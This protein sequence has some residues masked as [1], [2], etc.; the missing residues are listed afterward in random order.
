[1]SD[2]FALDDEGN[3]AVAQEAAANPLDPHDYRKG[4]FTGT[5][6]AVGQGLLRG[7]VAVGR[8]LELAGSVP[9]AFAEP[10]LGK[11]EGDLT[12]A[13][14]GAIDPHLR[15]AT[16]Y[17]TPNAEE[18]GAAAN[19]LGGFAEAGIPLALGGGNPVPLIATA[20]LS[21]AMR[22]SDEGVGPNTAAAVGT[23][24]AAANAVGFKVPFLGN[25]LLTRVAS[26]AAGNMAVGAGSTEAS[27]LL[28]QA[29]GNNE[30]A[31]QYNPLD[32]K[33]R[34]VDTLMG[35]AF[36]TLAHFADGHVTPTERDAAL[37]TLNAKHAAEDT[38]PGTPADLGAAQAHQAAID[39]AV[40]SILR[41]EP[42]VAPPA[43][44]EANFKPRDFGPAPEVPAELKA[45]DAELT[46]PTLNIEPGRDLTPDQRAIEER[47]RQQI[48][49]DPE[50]AVEA[51]SKLPDSAGGKII[52][53]DTARELSPDYL[54]DRTQ[55][56]A[57]HEPASALMKYLFAKKLA[58]E[59]GPGERPVVLFSAGGTG[60]GKTTALEKLI[61]ARVAE[62]QV[63]YDTNLNTFDSGVKKIDQALA[64]RKEVTIAYVYRHPIEALVKGALTRAMRQEKEFG[65]GRTVPVPDHIDTHTGSRDVIEQLMAHYANDKRVQFQVIDN[66]HG[67]NGAR[68]ANIA[69]IPK[70]APEAHNALR[71]QAY[72][73]LTEE[74]QA[75]RISESVYRGFSAGRE[76]PANDTRGMVE[77]SG[78]A[79]GGIPQQADGQAQV[80]DGWASTPGDNPGVTHF[81]LEGT[82]ATVDALPIGR[83]GQVLYFAKVN[84]HDIGGSEFYS[85][86]D[87]KAAALEAASRTIDLTPADRKWFGDSQALDAN[88]QPL[89]LFRGSPK[90]GG[91]TLS[92]DGHGLIYLTEDR[93]YAAQ[94]AGQGADARVH[95]FILKTEKPLQ[96]S[97]V[98]D[99]PR[100]WG[101]DLES[102]GVKDASKLIAAD[103][104][105]KD[106]QQHRV[107][108]DAIIQGN[109]PLL[110]AIKA[111]GYDSV[112]YRERMLEDSNPH[113][114]WVAWDKTRL[115]AAEPPP[116][117]K[118]FTATGRQIDVRPKVVEASK[119]LTSDHPKYPQ[120]LQPRQ[121]GARAASSAQVSEI[122]QNLRP[123]L[124]GQS[125]TADTGAPI[126]GA[127]NA[128]ESGNGRVMALRRVYA[129]GG[130]SAQA[131]RD[132]LTSQGHDITGMNE[133]VL[134]RERATKLTDEERKAFTVEANKPAIMAMSAVERAQADAQQLNDAAL[135][136]LHPG[137][138]TSPANAGFARAFLSSMAPGERNALLD[139]SGN[140]SQEGVRRMQAAIL[141]RAYGRSPESLSVLSRMLESTD[142]ESRSVLG[143]LTD[144][145]PA[146]AKLREAVDQGQVDP[147]FDLSGKVAKAVEELAA[148]RAKGQSVGEALKQTDMLNPRDPQ[149][150][151]VLKSFYNDKGTRLAPRDRIAGTLAKY[152]DDAAAVSRNQGDM[153]GSS[154]RTPDAL[155]EQ[156]REANPEP[157][158]A[159]QEDLF[160]VNA[161]RQAVDSLDIR[162]P[163]GTFD[164]S[165]APVTMSARELLAQS[166][167]EIQ[168][169]QNDAKA[170]EAAADCYLSTGV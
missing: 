39:Q 21:G 84:G 37:S 85:L 88:D 118:V 112:R 125:A 18:N 72:K 131:Y 43:V 6:S 29:T 7:G 46:G 149:V 69:D 95:Q 166:D 162:V 81:A 113:W 137:E 55:S 170:Y 23:I 36:G 104:G 59:P 86:Q 1:M 126:V 10:L 142:A 98:N 82:G 56:A 63:V 97:N 120:E 68:E 100:Y 50:A 114:S 143:A 152:A 121:R 9:I 44:T 66:S 119:L 53:T 51:Y 25:S 20:G 54:A 160:A 74:L 14:F 48:G 35:V 153:F 45:L 22:A 108:F 109:K 127:D 117:Q 96:I 76:P 134:V 122:A 123:E 87:A 8:S 105:L 33:A 116:T 83:N 90:P 150:D 58:E 169:A 17:W 78:Q 80:A 19:V 111:A 145:A 2:L 167:A 144:A 34:A 31:D 132:F 154:E 103:E 139:A 60:A 135:S 115:R 102:R 130:Q 47:F 11:R 3:R 155:L 164:E 67:P 24:E 61:P 107:D 40:N 41:G 79:D 92:G 168:A 133:P 156:A 30:L 148:V 89:M 52:N 157:K 49:S 57:V 65:S 13:Y 27:R 129:E 75:G 159:K 4:L 101:M 138:L 77:G 91:T 38:A 26:G 165:G 163:T 12:D 73:S 110:E 151:A 161:A 146:F 106:T 16:D 71:E 62:A 28:L 128:V 99:Y 15:D 5:V 70:V 93:N 124:L 158:A 42:V 136:Q 141:A 140:L 64:A 94:Y 32:L 147:A